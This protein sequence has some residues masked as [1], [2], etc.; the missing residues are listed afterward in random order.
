MLLSNLQYIVFFQEEI[1]SILEDV[2]GYVKVIQLQVKMANMMNIAPKDVTL[3]MQHHLEMSTA[4][5]HQTQIKNTIAVD[6]VDTNTIS[7]SPKNT[8]LFVVHPTTS[9]QQSFPSVHPTSPQQSFHSINQMLAHSSPLT[10]YLA[11]I[12]SGVI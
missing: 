8:N 12:E 9:P 4:M 5:N 10:A 7:H 6:L 11:A 1:S 3:V 2:T